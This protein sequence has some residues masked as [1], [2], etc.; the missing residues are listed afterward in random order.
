MFKGRS[1]KGSDLPVGLNDH[2]FGKRTFFGSRLLGTVWAFRTV[3]KRELAIIA[4]RPKLKIGE[5][6]RRC[7][8]Y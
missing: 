6:L 1:P 4:V 7:I 3:A 8:I 2:P 5:F